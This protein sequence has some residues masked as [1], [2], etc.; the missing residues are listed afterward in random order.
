M[1]RLLVIFI[2]L[3]SGLTSSWGQAIFQQQ[4]KMGTYLCEIHC[5][6]ILNNQDILIGGFVNNAPANTIREYYLALLDSNANVKWVVKMDYPNTFTTQFYSGGFREIEPINDQQTE[7][8]ALWINDGPDSTIK[9]IALRFDINGQIVSSRGAYTDYASYGYDVRIFRKPNRPLYLTYKSPKGFLVSSYYISSTDTFHAIGSRLFLPPEISPGYVQYGVT[10]TDYSQGYGFIIAESYSKATFG[11][12]SSFFFISHINEQF[13]TSW[14]KM[15]Y[16]DLIPSINQVTI[17]T[18]NHDIYIVGY[19]SISSSPFTE[20]YQDMAIGFV[21]K[22]DSSGNLQWHKRYYTDISLIFET[23]RLSEISISEN[24]D[25]IYLT[26]QYNEFSTFEKPILIKALASNGDVVEAIKFAIVDQ[27]ES[28]A[29]YIY[30][31]KLESSNNKLLWIGTKT[32]TLFENDQLE[33]L[34]D[35]VDFEVLTDTLHGS[36]MEIPVTQNMVMRNLYFDSV[37]VESAPISINSFDRCGQIGIDE[38]VLASIEVYPNPF[39][40]QVKIVTE[41]T[42]FVV[43]LFDVNGKK[44]FEVSNSSLLNMAEISPGIY[45]LQIFFDDANY[46]RFFKII[47]T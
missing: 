21:V 32:L 12:D 23:L 14:S 1:R 4:F 22:L 26:G 41:A 45:F 10:P 47:K 15:I 6:R 19:E 40:D 37:D 7:F 2:G 8:L 42:E 46:S 35:L 36:T 9:T 31:T 33:K 44:V 16:F 18:V 43:F 3:F 39:T 28:T 5:T 38:S 25:T 30:S 20:V 29:S 27:N 34:C 13:A 24:R 17:D 11:Y